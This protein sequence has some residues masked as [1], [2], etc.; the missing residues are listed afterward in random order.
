MKQ[1]NKS[2]KEGISFADAL[3]RDLKMCKI[4]A[5]KSPKTYVFIILNA[6][7]TALTPYSS[8]YFSAKL[9][10]E[11]SADRDPQRL[12]VCVLLILGSLA[13]FSLASALTSHLENAYT[14]IADM[15]EEEILMDKISSL[16]FVDADS[17]RIFDLYSSVKQTQNFQGYGI[18]ALKYYVAPFIKSIFSI[19]G[20][21]ALT[22]SLFTE[23]V[24][25]GSLTFLNNPIFAV[26]MIAAILG[27]IA[28]TTLLTNKAMGLFSD[29]NSKGRFGNRAF[30]FFGFDVPGD[31]K[32]AADLRIYD[33]FENI[34]IPSMKEKCN[35]FG[36]G[37]EY[38]KLSK[39]PV[40]FYSMIITSISVIVTGLI[41][42]FVCL[43]ALG[44]AFG[45]DMVTQYIGSATALFIA[46]S[47]LFTS[48]ISLKNNGMFLEPVFEI[49]DT[50]NAMY[51]G[52]LTT[53]KR[54]DRN[55]EIEF[56]DVSFKYPESDDYALRH[57]NMK[58]RVGER[59]AVVGMNGSG[60]TTF[61]KLLCRLYD[62]DEGEI[63]LN[64]INIQKY[65]YDE[66]MDIFSIVF[67]DFNLLAL[68]LGQNVA[69]CKNY[70]SERVNDCLRKAGFG[71]RLD[72]LENGL[73]TSLYR[74]L[75]NDG[76]NV[77]GGEAQKIAIARALYK[78]AP[79]IIL[80][81]PTAAL[82]PIAEA[83]IYSKFN[84]IVGDKT[85]IYIS[86]RLSS[87][88]F[89]DEIVV[90][91]HGNVIEQGTHDALIEKNGKYTELWNAQAQYYKAT[92]ENKDEFEI[93]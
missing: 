92:D 37:S 85:A 27:G 60:K 15:T 12:F 39:G 23:N 24:P 35:V 88:K 81:E 87:C 6:L 68:P 5:K 11:L 84:D 46:I 55:Y 28:L 51:K 44:G 86:H 9:I 10:A 73:E 14:S 43:K 78:D 72:S 33:Q 48:L 47:D 4:L 79:F 49:L 22:V 82:D 64:G 80:D 26:L 62:P 32:R 45:L 89:C 65:K 38:D 34:C 29:Y 76:I 69:G 13:V 90:F 17:Q 19:I 41:Y 7:V 63:L 20:G 83:E 56:K 71:D 59:L 93:R 1:K 40:G 77:S 52:S 21:V 53:E 91:D 2:V 74:E 3:R 66:Y 31:D 36:P 57:V 75:D 25:S 70:D 42:V 54:S 8:I 30:S 16:D 67:Q 61:I 58:F 50:P 18:Y